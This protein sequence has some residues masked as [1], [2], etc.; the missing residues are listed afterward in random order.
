VPG[1]LHRITLI[2]GS[3][4]LLRPGTIGIHGWNLASFRVAREGRKRFLEANPFGGWFPLTAAV[5]SGRR[6]KFSLLLGIEA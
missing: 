1:A 2:G 3:A 4:L 5:L 6:E